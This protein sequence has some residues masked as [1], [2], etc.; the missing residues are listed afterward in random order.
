M[1]TAH[2]PPRRGRPPWRL[3]APPH[4]APHRGPRRA[5]RQL[6]R[7]H[8]PGL[9]RLRVVRHK[10]LRRGPLRRAGLPPVQLRHPP[11]AWERLRPRAGGRQDGRH[12]DWHG[13]GPGALRRRTVATE[14]GA[15][16]L[17][18]GRHPARR[19]RLPPDDWRWRHGVGRAGERAHVRGAR[20]RWGAHDGGQDPPARRHH[21]V[22]ERI[23]RHLRGG[24]GRHILVPLRHP[25][26][27]HGDAPR[28]P[29]RPCR[30]KRGRHRGL[31]GEL[32]IPVGGDERRPVPLQPDH[33]RGGRL[34][35]QRR[36]PALPHAGPRH[37]HRHRRPRARHRGHAQR[38]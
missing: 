11:G 22:G 26:R 24:G 18:R 16:R 15:P 19:P 38:A 28:A 17:H 12:M 6:R 5:A 4:R 13:P 32:G 35:P 20:R 31:G 23:P 36:R 14:Q 9:A 21:G 27:A 29:R 34:P 37:R 3:L 25:P 30:R 2:H 7:R 10:R 33:G 8:L 1:P